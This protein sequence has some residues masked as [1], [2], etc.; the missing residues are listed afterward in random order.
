VSGRESQDKEREQD[1]V[2]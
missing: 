2:F 1:F